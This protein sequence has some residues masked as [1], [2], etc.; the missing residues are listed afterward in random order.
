MMFNI[1]ITYSNR[2]KFV[3]ITRQSE[4]EQELFYDQLITYILI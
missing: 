1:I 4:P 2:I 3:K